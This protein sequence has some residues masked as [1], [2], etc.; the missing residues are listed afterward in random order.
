MVAVAAM[1]ARN[2]SGQAN[3]EDHFVRKQRG[4]TLIELMIA[5]ALTGILL[6]MGVP[7]LNLFVS[8]ARQTSVINDFVSSMHTAR[9][10][11]ITTNTRV[12][13]CP[14]SDGASCDVVD[15][16]EGWIVFGDPDSDRVVDPDERVVAT[17]EGAAGLTIESPEFGAFLTYR[18]N[19]RVM[20]ASLDG[21]SG[22]FTVC[23]KRGADRAKVLI[24]DLS[25]RPRLSKYLADGSSPACS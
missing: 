2:E 3:H 20:N 23:D 14:S 16:E 9:S 25:G 1:L 8:N 7:A 24:V 15:W 17:A 13:I 21:S 4:F 22:E 11:A 5:V 6:G 18:P 19:G 10:T 12:T